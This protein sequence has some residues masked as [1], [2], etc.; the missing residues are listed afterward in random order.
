MPVP[1]RETVEVGVCASLVIVTEPVVDPD[2][3]GANVA[4]NA[5]DWPA[6]NVT[7]AATPLTLKPAP[8]T[9]SC[10]IFK[11]LLPEFLTVTAWVLV[12]S[13]STLPNL[14]LLVLNESCEAFLP[15]LPFNFTFEEPPPR[16]V[17]ALSVP[18]TVPVVE[19][20]KATLNC[21]DWPGA[22]VSGIGRPEAENSDDDKLSCVMLTD[23]LPVLVSVASCVAVLPTETFGKLKAAG[24]I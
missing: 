7:G 11:S 10:E 24:V 22:S 9:A 21:A 16:E 15:E 20:L 19:L 6:G 18:E 2:F 5:M 12:P 17:M 23:W 13:T 4:C 1:E 8:L 3:V 14:R